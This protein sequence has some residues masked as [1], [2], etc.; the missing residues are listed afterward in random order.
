MTDRAEFTRAAETTAALPLV[1]IAAAHIAKRLLT[2]AGR[3]HGR[4]CR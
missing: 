2:S 3:P 4:G 1:G